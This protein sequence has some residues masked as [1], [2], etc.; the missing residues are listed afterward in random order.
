MYSYKS[1][2]PLQQQLRHDNSQPRYSAE[3]H[4]QFCH[5]IVVRSAIAAAI[6]KYT[7][8]TFAS[9]ALSTLERSETVL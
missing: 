6:N 9:T 7:E 1:S 5:L 3:H 4:T 2:S 8:D